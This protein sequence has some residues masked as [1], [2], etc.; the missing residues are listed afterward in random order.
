MDELGH[1][2]RPPVPGVQRRPLAGTLEPHNFKGE[3]GG[4]L[5]TYDEV[6]LNDERAYKRL[7]YSRSAR[8]EHTSQDTGQG[9]GRTHTNTPTHNTHKYSTNSTCTSSHRVRTRGAYP[10]FHLLSKHGLHSDTLYPYIVPPTTARAGLYRLSV[11]SEAGSGVTCSPR[12]RGAA[13]RGT[14]V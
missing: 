12:V 11:S 14:C 4:D 2:P 6:S 10:I 3:V 13:P 1:S 8:P 9:H 7:Q 5:R